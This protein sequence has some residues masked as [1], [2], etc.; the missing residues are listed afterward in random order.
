MYLYIVVKSNNYSYELIT[1]IFCCYYY[2]W[3]QSY[4]RQKKVLK[5][6]MITNSLLLVNINTI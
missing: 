3:I 5:F 2:Q 1:I 4:I 6:V